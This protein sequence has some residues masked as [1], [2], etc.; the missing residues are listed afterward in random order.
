MLF[1]SAVGNW[2][3]RAPLR[4]PAL[5]KTIAL[6]HAAIILSYLAWL[7]WP[8]FVADPDQVNPNGPYSNFNSG[9]LYSIIVFLDIVHDLSAIGNRL[10]VDRDIVPV[11]VGPITPDIMY[12]LTQVNAVMVRIDLLCKL[13]AP[14]L[15]PLVT[16][17]FASRSSWILLLSIITAL[18]FLGEILCVFV[19]FA[20][21]KEEL[22]TPKTAPPEQATMGLGTEDQYDYLKPEIG[23]WPKKLFIALYQDPAARLKH[24]FSFPMWPASVSIALL[25]LTVLAYSA[26][27][28]T[29]LL[30]IG[31]ELSSIT[32][33]RASGAILALSSTIITPW[34]VNFLRER[35]NRRAI[36]GQSQDD[37]EGSEG[38]IV[39]TVGIWGISS[40]LLCMIPVVLVLWNL[41]PPPSEIHAED[42]HGKSQSPH[43]IIPLLFFGFLSLSRIGHYTAQL[44]VQELGQVEIPA[45]HRSTFAGTEQ[46]F[47]SLGALG[48]W[49]ATMVFSRPDQFRM[50]ALGSLIMVAISVAV[51]GLWWR[52]PIEGRKEEYE[53]VA[54]ID[55]GRDD[56][57]DA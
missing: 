4:M 46:S 9:L 31:F 34:A 43:L 5:I 2:I 44:M 52:T 39:R 35:N 48:H 13:V 12:S 17:F 32:I 23:L 41:S 33:A 38:R 1:A 10:A 16:A 54:M 56:Q 20:E 19:L 49:A 51:Y 37:D 53:G 47:R 36:G 6:N 25:Q 29:Y 22:L 11:L 55:L 7:N 45:S 15:L 24:F 40:Q 18:F 27:L 57:S 3:D 26:T 42:E 28:I 21:C 8:L 50:L 14:S 30:E